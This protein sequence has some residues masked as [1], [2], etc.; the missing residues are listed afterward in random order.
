MNSSN[1][2]VVAVLVIIA[3]ITTIGYGV[4]RHNIRSPNVAFTSVNFKVNYQGN[5]SGYLEPTLY[6]VRNFTNVSVNNFSTIYQ[7]YK[8]PN[9]QW[10]LYFVFSLGY[11]SSNPVYQMI[12]SYGYH[13]ND[14][15]VVDSITTTT[16][17][18]SLN[19]SFENGYS[20][21]SFITGN[22]GRPFPY[23]PN[24]IYTRFINTYVQI[25]TMFYH[26]P[27]NITINAS[28]SAKN[29]VLYHPHFSMVQEGNFTTQI[30]M[31]ANFTDGIGLPGNNLYG[32]SN[33]W[34][35][36]GTFGLTSKFNYSIV[37]ISVS[38]PFKIPVQNYAKPVIRYNLGANYTMIPSYFDEVIFNISVPN[39][40]LLTNLNVT[41]YVMS[42]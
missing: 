33:G 28:S 35:F 8:A 7:I 17:G 19:S 16:P 25:G 4:Y 24:G 41:V 10:I 21:E 26:G 12:N 18:F 38:S 15:V 20:G 1:K 27:L 42:T 40:P 13:F 36:A 34:N 22:A 39:G 37:N 31:S 6:S 14:S 23:V 9:G 32:V 3:L 11:N 29:I 2:K 5:H 30:N